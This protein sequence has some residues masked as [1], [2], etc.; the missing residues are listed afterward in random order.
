MTIETAAV[1]RVE[2]IYRD[3]K[4]TARAVCADPSGLKF[5]FYLLRNGTDRVQHS[6]YSD[7]LE[8]SFTV[9]DPGYYRIT[10]FAKEGDAAPQTIKSAPVFAAPLEVTPAALGEVGP[11]VEALTLAGER[12]RYPALYYPKDGKRLFVMLPSA[13]APGTVLPAFSRWTWRDLFPGDVLCIADPTLE[14]NRDLRLGWMLGRQDAC[15]TDDLVPFVTSLARARGIESKDIVFWGSSAGGFAALAM[16]ARVEGSTAVAINAQTDALAYEMPSQVDLVRRVC[17]AG[18]PATEIRA[19][20]AERVDMRAL[21]RARRSRAVLVQNELDAHHHKVHFGPM[22]QALGG[23]VAD[24]I[25]TADQHTA[26]VY[27]DAGGH[28]PET[29]E[30]VAQIVARVCEAA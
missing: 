27:R 5:A 30:M 26:W 14:L 7:A 22:W 16:A 10:C 21:W 9:T 4:I 2:A 11:G 3:G 1:E 24:G 8:R 17:F 28:V 6:W 23:A 12:W 20:H 15:A 29:K 25:S 18:A 13:I 19:A